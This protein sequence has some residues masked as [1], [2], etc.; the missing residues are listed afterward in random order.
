MMISEVCR[1]NAII[2]SRV[3]QPATVDFRSNRQYS[4][5]LSFS[6]GYHNPHFRS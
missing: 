6:F 5:S 4:V 3:Q 2:E 1:D